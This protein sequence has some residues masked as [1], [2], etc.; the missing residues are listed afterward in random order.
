[1]RRRRARANKKVR[2]RGEGGRSRKETLAIALKRFNGKPFVNEQDALSFPFPTP[3]PPTMFAPF[4]SMLSHVSCASFARLN[5]KVND[6][7]MYA[8]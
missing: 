4:Q 6:C 8:C 2:V 1:M 3:P 7:Y 5:E